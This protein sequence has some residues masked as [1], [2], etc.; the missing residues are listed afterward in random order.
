MPAGLMRQPFRLSELPSGSIFLHSD[1]E[2]V[3]LDRGY[4]GRGVPYIFAVVRDICHVCICAGQALQPALHVAEVE[5]AESVTVV[6]AVDEGVVA[7]LEEPDGI[8]WLYVSVVVFGQ[9]GPDEIS[10]SCIISIE[11]QVLLASVKNLDEHLGCVR[12][13]CD[14][15]QIS[16]ISEVFSLD[17]QRLAACKVIYSQLNVL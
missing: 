13:P 1:P 14:V 6:S 16:V 12:S 4:L 7:A 9:Y 2:E 10:C 17:I 15:G 5:V 8:L 11:F 3:V